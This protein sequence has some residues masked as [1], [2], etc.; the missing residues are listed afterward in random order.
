MTQS[1]E[2]EKVRKHGGELR[3]AGVPKG[4]AMEWD[5]YYK[6]GNRQTFQGH[7]PKDVNLSKLRETIEDSGA[8]CA[9]GHG[10]TK[11]WT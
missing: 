5:G 1:Q 3:G 2:W 8:R 7:D 9:I 6:V 4:E 10:V 11:S